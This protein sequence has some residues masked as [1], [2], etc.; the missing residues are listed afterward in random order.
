MGVGCISYGGRKY[1]LDIAGTTYYTMEKGVKTIA[2]E[3]VFQ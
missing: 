3:R 1:S 2:W